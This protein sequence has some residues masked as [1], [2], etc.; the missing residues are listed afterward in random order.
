M[1]NDALDENSWLEALS[2][3]PDPRADED[4]A[5]RTR[6]RCHQMLT[7]RRNRTGGWRARVSGAVPMVEAAAVAALALFYLESALQ[8]A[9]VL[10]G[11]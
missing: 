10:L 1:T 8:H 3:L 6:A 2:G 11:R 7:R 4:R 9:L 5:A